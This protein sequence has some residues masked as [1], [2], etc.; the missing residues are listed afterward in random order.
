MRNRKTRT[1]ACKCL[2]ILVLVCRC[3]F[4]WNMW[5]RLFVT[6]KRQP[7]HGYWKELTK[8]SEETTRIQ[9][10]RFS[11][12]ISE[13]KLLSK[14]FISNLVIRNT[15]V[16]LLPHTRTSHIHT[17]MTH[18]LNFTKTFS[19][20]MELSRVKSMPKRNWPRKKK[21]SCWASHHFTFV[22]VLKRLLHRYII[23]GFHPHPPHKYTEQHF[24]CGFLT[25]NFLF[26]LFLL[27]YS[28]NIMI[29]VVALF[30]ATQP[31]LFFP[32]FFRSCVF[33]VFHLVRSFALSHFWHWFR[34][35]F[36]LLRLWR[37]NVC[38]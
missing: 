21:L 2:I 36:C 29:N 8:K 24:G 10:F 23:R 26:L 13:T 18:S 34:Q 9:V 11:Y 27:H 37:S 20:L 7:I 1:R 17:K 12:A 4:H 15:H 33:M 35:Y 22:L 14:N 31:P 6:T 25:L 19:W 28:Y 38:I 30:A 32:H 5:F 16:L 3:V